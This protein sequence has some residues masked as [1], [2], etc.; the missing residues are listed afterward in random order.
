MPR[1]SALTN[2]LLH[3]QGLTYTPVATNVLSSFPSGVSASVSQ[4]HNGISKSIYF[5]GSQTSSLVAV[6]NTAYA[7][8]PVT[9]EFW[10]Y[11]TVA[12]GVFLD[13]QNTT[14]GQDT[15]IFNNGIAQGDR[16]GAVGLTGSSTAWTPGSWRH[17]VMTLWSSTGSTTVADRI[18]GWNNGV[19]N[20]P[21]GPGVTQLPSTPTDYT[22]TNETRIL[23]G[24]NQYSPTNA[25]S[26]MTGYISEIRVSNNA[27]Y[28]TAGATFTPPA[29]AFTVDA[30]TLNLIR[31][32]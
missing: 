22:A 15:I 17:L 21:T 29:S 12:G 10:V 11:D 4:T 3:G 20:W 31:A 2:Q 6:T 7:T 30:N 16:T 1:L 27:R 24:M 14:T 25:N 26:P 8:Y 19:S 5:S 28:G 9:V 18:T 32:V 23:L 13:L